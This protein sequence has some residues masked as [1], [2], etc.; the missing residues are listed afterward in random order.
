[1]PGSGNQVKNCHADI[2]SKLPF[3]ILYDVVV[4]HGIPAWRNKFQIS[5]QSHSIKCCMQVPRNW[6][7]V[8]R[9]NEK[10]K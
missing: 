5:N 9:V 7:T 2:T 3:D 1:M 10:D 6:G 4:K 8:G